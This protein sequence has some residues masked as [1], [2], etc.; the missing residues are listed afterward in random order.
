Y[1]LSRLIIYMFILC[2]LCLFLSFF[3][4]QAEDG[5]RDF[6]V[7]GVQTCALPI[8]RGRSSSAT[9]PDRRRATPEN[10]RPQRRGSDNRESPQ[11]AMWLRAS[12]SALRAGQCSTTGRSMS[13]W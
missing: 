2:F 6:H 4:F 9:A 3:F 7:T 13:R 1:L 12:T 10:Q 5:I 11:P 8:S